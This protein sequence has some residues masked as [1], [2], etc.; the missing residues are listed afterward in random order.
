MLEAWREI[1]LERV[2][3][4]TKSYRETEGEPVLIRRAKATGKILAE[5]NISIREGEIIADN[6][7]IKPRSGI[8]SPEMDPYW[9]YEELDTLHSR[10]QDQFFIREEDKEIY[11][12]ELYPYWAG[13]SLKD[14]INARLS[15]EVKETQATEIVKLNQTDKGQVH[16]IMGYQELLHD[17]LGHIL[18]RVR[19]ELGKQADNF[20][21]QAALITLEA[22]T[23]HILR[24][25]KLAKEMAAREQDEVRCAELLEMSRVCQKVWKHKGL[26]S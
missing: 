15:Q 14:V 19:E 26:W 5:V 2:W 17:G 16:I 7:T 8:A 9:I 12:R 18:Q 10:P 24:Y 23:Q 6:R 20:F 11:R 21:Y 3:L 4:Y 22:T 1:S 13:R 25:A